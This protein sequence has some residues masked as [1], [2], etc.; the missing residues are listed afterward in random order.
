MVSVVETLR[1]QA[2]G[3]R[4]WKD[5]VLALQKVPEDACKCWDTPRWHGTREFTNHKVAVTVDESGD[6]VLYGAV[7][8]KY[9]E[10]GAKLPAEWYLEFRPNRG[11]ICAATVVVWGKRGVLGHAHTQ[12]ERGE[13]PDTASAIGSILS[14]LPQK[15][16][17]GR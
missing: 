4:L 8:P 15:K 5:V 3:Y 17:H 10:A 9:A 11:G 1:R 13:F 7:I 16:D 12:L 2:T 6:V 14:R